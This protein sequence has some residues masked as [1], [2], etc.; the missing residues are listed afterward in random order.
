M[1]H[2]FILDGHTPVAEPDV[3][4]WGRWLE[5]ADRTV[6]L[7]KTR[8]GEVSTVFLGLDHNFSDEG[9]PILFES[10]VFGGKLNGEGRRYATWDEAEAGH[11]ELVLLTTENW[12]SRLLKKLRWLQIL[13]FALI[14]LDSII[15][16]FHPAAVQISTL[17][18]L[19]ASFGV[20]Q[21]SVNTLKRLL[22][23]S[24]R[25]HA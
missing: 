20:Q 3:V 9:P 17:G 2:K 1:M 15:V 13:T 24:G 7:T 21:L 5:E 25:K 12:Y 14:V 23:K 10:L 18:M 6:G 22:R 16:G 8:A 11:W 4:K 19:L